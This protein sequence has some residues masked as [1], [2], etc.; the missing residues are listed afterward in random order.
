MR[1]PPLPPLKVH[2][3][4]LPG[5]WLREMG[6]ARVKLMV[7]STTKSSSLVSQPMMASR[8][9]AAASKACSTTVTTTAKR[10]THHPASVTRRTLP[11]T[12]QMVQRTLT[13]TR[14]ELERVSEVIA[15]R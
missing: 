8:A 15:I 2:Q 6:P 11:R 13:E 5:R 9:A 7:R 1:W 3:S 4:S 12:A 10:R 14:A